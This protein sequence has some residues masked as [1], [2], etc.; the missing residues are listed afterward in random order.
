MAPYYEHVCAQLGWQ[1]DGARLQAMQAANKQQ[2]EDLE[3]KITDAETN[4]GETGAGQ[5]QLQ[6]GV[7]QSS[8]SELCSTSLS[9]CVQHHGS[10][11]RHVVRQ[12][13]LRPVGSSQTGCQTGSSQRGKGQRLLHPSMCV[14]WQ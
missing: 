13:S 2:L 9:A 4:A 8:S 11:C 12:G 3:A 6:A 7:Y 10:T 14:P 5:R 1:V